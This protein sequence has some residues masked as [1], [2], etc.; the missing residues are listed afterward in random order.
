VMEHVVPHVLIIP[1]AQL[2]PIVLP[3]V[4]VTMVTLALLADHVLKPLLLVV[5]P[6]GHAALR[7]VVV[8]PK[9]V[10][11]PILHH[12]MVVPIVLD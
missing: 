4:S 12:Q 5:G 6:I 9:P 1:I 7:H 10:L 11:V 3:T 2:D 8:V